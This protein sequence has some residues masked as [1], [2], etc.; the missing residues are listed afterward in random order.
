LIAARPRPIEVA[1][2]ERA[3]AA[4]WRFEA[5]RSPL[6]RAG[7]EGYSPSPAA[8]ARP[9]ISGPRI[10]TQSSPRS[11]PSSSAVSRGCDHGKNPLSILSRDPFDGTRLNWLFPCERS[12]PP[13]PPQ[14]ASRPLVIG[15]ADADQSGRGGSPF[16]ADSFNNRRPGPVQRSGRSSQFRR[17]LGRVD[18]RNRPHPDRDCASPPRRSSPGLD[19]R[20]VLRAKRWRAQ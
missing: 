4:R 10:V 11:L 8:T 12:R 16:A 3:R 18:A 1:L 9:C 6:G 19:R 2:P 20:L 14:S 13:R 17:D 15:A 5:G 7:G